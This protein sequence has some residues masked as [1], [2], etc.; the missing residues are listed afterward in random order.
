MNPVDQQIDELEIGIEV[1]RKAVDRAKALDELSR[2]RNFK[3]IILEGYFEEEAQRLVLLK[4]DP[5]MQSDE[6]QKALDNAIIGIGQLRQ[7]F[8]TINQFGRM[9]AQSIAEDEETLDELREEAVA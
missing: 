2:N 4:S 3:K 8:I 7:H 6:Q 1:A 9:A 5:N